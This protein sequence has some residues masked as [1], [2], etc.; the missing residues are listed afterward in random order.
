MSMLLTLEV[1]DILVYAEDASNTQEV[2]DFCRSH[3][4]AFEALYV[5]LHRSD[6]R[7]DTVPVGM[8]GQTFVKF[9]NGRVMAIDSDKITGSTEIQESEKIDS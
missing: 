8:P 2:I 4:Y 5:S 3:F 9:T 7:G 6:A 1:R